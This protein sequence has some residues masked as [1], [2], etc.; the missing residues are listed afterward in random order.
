MRRLVPMLALTLVATGCASPLLSRFRVTRTTGRGAHVLLVGDSNLAL[1]GRAVESVMQ[2]RFTPTVDAQPG[3]ATS[4]PRWAA[5]LPSDL[6]QSR[7]RV[8]VVQLGTNDASVDRV[9][10]LPAAIDRIMRSIPAQVPVLWSNVRIVQGAGL[11]W[12]VSELAADISLL[13]ATARWP[14]LH[15]LDYAGHFAG[16]PEWIPPTAIHLTPAG[17]VEYARW[18]TA[19]VAPYAR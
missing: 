12:V 10:F 7:P 13:G 18:V 6:A 3:I 14:N 15:L 1:S 16:H 9:K 5:W 19:Q 2:Q 11:P 8:V 4:D 17:Q